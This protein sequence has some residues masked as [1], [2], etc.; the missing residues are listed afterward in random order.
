MGAVVRTPPSA[1]DR[2]AELSKRRDNSASLTATLPRTARSHV[3]QLLENLCLRL[4][5]GLR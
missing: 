3:E 4:S 5:R 1:P 2:R